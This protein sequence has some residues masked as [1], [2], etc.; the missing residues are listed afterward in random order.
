MTREENNNTVLTHCSR[1]SVLA[2][3]IALLFFH[4]VF[5]LGWCLYAS[6]L[7][8]LI[9][10]ASVKF[11]LKIEKVWTALGKVSIKIIGPVVL[12][13]VYY[14]CLLPLAIIYRRRFGDFL[15][16]RQEYKTHFISV[17]RTFTKE[18]FTKMW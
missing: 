2:V 15:M 9:G 13:A 3:C 12:G 14:L 10:L 8:G 7:T 4:I 5:S 16:L 17:N 11:S 18:S 1:E 6:F